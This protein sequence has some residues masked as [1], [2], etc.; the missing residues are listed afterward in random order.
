[1]TTDNAIEISAEITP[2]PNTLKFNVSKSLLKTGSI[3]FPD[4][5]KAKGVLLPERL[6]QIDNVLGVMIGQSFVTITKHPDSSWPSLVPQ[7]IETLKALLSSDETLF[8]EQASVNQDRA[9]GNVDNSGIERKIREILDNEIRLAVAMDGGDIIFYGYDNGIVR[10]H[11]EGS[12][13]ACPSSLMTLKMGV[14][15]RLRALIPEV[16]EVVQV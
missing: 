15:S 1:M 14:E 16:R 3:N 4:K 8:P 12:C 5:E 6:F 7:V 13:S 10:L 9:C 2:N 11:L